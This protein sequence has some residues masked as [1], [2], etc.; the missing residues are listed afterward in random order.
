[1]KLV[2]VID[3]IEDDKIVVINLVDRSGSL[4]IKKECFDFKIYE[5]L[6]LEI[7]FIP[8]PQKGERVKAEI[9]KL[10]SELLRRSKKK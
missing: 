6:W 4:Y 2:G 1:M 8:N 3:R 10:Q 7:S 9:Q 5:G